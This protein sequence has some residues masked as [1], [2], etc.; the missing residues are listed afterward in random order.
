[1]QED[2]AS[3]GYN[4][5]LHMLVSSG[6]V[7]VM[8]SLF[9]A[10]ELRGPDMLADANVGALCYLLWSLGSLDITSAEGCAIMEMLTGIPSTLR[11]LIDNTVI[12]FKD[13]GS[14]SSAWSGMLYALA[15]GKLEGTSSGTK[16][17]AS[18]EF[19]QEMIDDIV[20]IH[21]GWLY[22]NEELVT[23][24]P[25]L[26]PYFLRP[27][28]HLSISD[29][30]KQ[31]LV[32]SPGL[33]PLLHHALFAEDDSH[34][35]K[36][37]AERNRAGIQLDGC[38]CLA[39]IALFDRGRELLQQDGSLVQALH[40]VQDHGLTREAQESAGRALVAL[41]GMEDLAASHGDIVAE[42]VML[43]YQWYAERQETLLE[44]DTA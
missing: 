34:P 18:F 40:V 11:F 41:R 29:E 24:S 36:D 28:V 3:V 25:V 7:D 9:K 26:P 5:L 27:V 14:T 31:L 12:L 32:K 8:A 16:A 42:H 23:L 1:M 21:S 37:M 2:L 20:S 17:L 44:V 38:E 30:Q 10:H 43:S 4:E 15:F 22:T 13:F 39:Q 19:S 35:R 6:I 33:V